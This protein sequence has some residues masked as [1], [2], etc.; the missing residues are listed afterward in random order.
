M[1]MR[2][3]VELTILFGVIVSL[4]TS[5][6]SGGTKFIPTNPNQIFSLSKFN[7][8]AIGPV[9]STQVTASDSDGITY[10]GSLAKVNREQEMYSG[11]MTTPSDI[12]ISLTGGGISLTQIGTSYIDSD[13]N[14]IAL[15]FEDTGETCTFVTPDSYPFF[16]KIADFGFLSDLLCDDGTVESTNWRVEDAGNGHVNFIASGPTRNQINVITDTTDLTFTING[17]GDIVFFKT[18]TTDLTTGY[19]LTIQ[20]V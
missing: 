15:V 6:D 4:L 1:N 10:T 16:F 8:T 7:T 14:T 2:M 19:M 13:G 11:V 20:S 18:V 12:R 17:S 9:Y 3:L 5:C